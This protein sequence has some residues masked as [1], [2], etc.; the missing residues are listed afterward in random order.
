MATHV[1][2]DCDPIR[3]RF[4]F[5]AQLIL[6]MSLLSLP[7]AATE[8]EQSGSPRPVRAASAEAARQAYLSILADG[9]KTTS[10][11]AAQLESDIIKNPH[12][13]AARTRL[14]SYYYQQM[15]ADRRARHVLWLIE[16]HP[17][18]EIFRVASDVA[19][20]SHTWHGL[21]RASDGDR[22][23]VLWLRAAA[24]PQQY[25]RP[26]ERG[27]SAQRRG[28]ATPARHSPAYRAGQSRLDCALSRNVRTLC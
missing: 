27:S 26:G 16:E 17:E 9:W 12:N 8:L 5:V 2:N 10:D 3:R 6:A 18:A 1:D 19:G 13:I 23:R 11:V 24:L 14:I 20:L 25:Q 28:L 22:A 15:I 21:N 7:S 4:P